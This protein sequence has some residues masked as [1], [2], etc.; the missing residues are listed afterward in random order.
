MSRRV[1]LRH[2]GQGGV[3]LVRLDP[4]AYNYDDLV[5]SIWLEDPGRSG[6]DDAPTGQVEV[7]DPSGIDAQGIYQGGYY[8]NR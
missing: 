4:A 7:R 2:V 6:Y 8:D 3:S 5:G 1:G